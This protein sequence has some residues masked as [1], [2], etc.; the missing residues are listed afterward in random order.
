MVFVVP[1]YEMM[2]PTCPANAPVTNQHPRPWYCALVGEARFVG[3]DEGVRV[4]AITA[5]LTMRPVVRA[6]MFAEGTLCP[7]AA[8]FAPWLCPSAVAGTSPNVGVPPACT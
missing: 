3:N 4:P 2:L 8:T 6:S 7:I 1:S 5:P